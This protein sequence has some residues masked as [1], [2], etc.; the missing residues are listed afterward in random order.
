MAI[1]VEQCDYLEND[2]PIPGQ[3]FVVMSF[4][5]PEKILP[6]KDL[7]LLQHFLHNLLN[8][9]QR[10]EQLKENPPTYEE[11]VDLFEGYKLTHE[12]NVNRIF[13]EQNDFQTS[14]RGIKIRGV[15]DTEKEARIR[16]KV[17]ERKD[18]YHNSF[19]GQV[20]F[21]LPWD[22][23]PSSIE[24]EEFGNEQL[25]Q[26]MKSKKENAQLREE[27]FN[28]E[29]V[30]K[31]TKLQNESKQKE[32][33]LN[34]LVAKNKESVD[35][36]DKLYEENKQRQLNKAAEE[37]KLNKEQQ[38]A[39]AKPKNKK[40]KKKSKKNQ[41]NSLVD[42]NS[43]VNNIPVEEAKTKIKELR[44]VL[45]TKDELYAKISK[46]NEDSVIMM[47]RN[48]T[49]V[50]NPASDKD[51]FSQEDPWLSRKNKQSED[52]KLNQLNNIL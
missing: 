35:K 34:T 32:T 47:E 16:S 49:S 44:E 4:V 1:P 37:A 42:K 8:D 52:L 31:Y 30:E 41:N 19:I 39:N 27:V 29:T 25:N 20:G 14:V 3:N 50:L 40:S 21:W 23:R 10:L 17:L 6:R 38:N 51:M 11:V 18:R 2:S 5:S 15:Y 43:F 12:D 24:H 36:N 13:N 9:K 45:N 22:P 28:Q 26:L 48:E 33:E 46:E 7:F